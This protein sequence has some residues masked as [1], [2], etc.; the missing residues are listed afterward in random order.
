MLIDHRRMFYSRE[1]EKWKSIKI[2]R[3]RAF[4]SSHSEWGKNGAQLVN[5]G[6]RKTRSSLIIAKWTLSPRVLPWPTMSRQRCLSQDCVCYST[7]DCSRWCCCSSAN[8]DRRQNFPW[9][10]EIHGRF[11]FDCSCF[12]TWF[13]CIELNGDCLKRIVTLYARLKHCRLR[14]FQKTINALQL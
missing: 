14:N 10:C 2:F 5:D 9:H 13:H 1:E 3:N 12:A 11:P 4:P 7:A 8:V 6:E